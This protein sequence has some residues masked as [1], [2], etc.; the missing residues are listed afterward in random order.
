[1]SFHRIL[2]LSLGRIFI[3]ALSIITGLYILFGVSGYVVSIDY[4][5]YIPTS[6]D[7]FIYIPTSIVYFIYIPTCT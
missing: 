7:Y 4:F 1:M 3:I 5:I 6:I 2:S